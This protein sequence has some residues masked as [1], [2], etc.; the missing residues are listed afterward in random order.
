MKIDDE[1]QLR[2]TFDNNKSL[3]HQI[4]LQEDA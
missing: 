4:L 1:N 2:T 3:T